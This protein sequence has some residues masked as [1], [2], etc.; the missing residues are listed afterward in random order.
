MRARP[1]CCRHHRTGVTPHVRRFPRPAPARRDERA[2]R[3]AGHRLHPHLGNRLHRRACAGPLRRTA[4]IRLHT[5]RAGRRAVRPHRP[6][7]AAQFRHRRARGGAQ[8]RRRLAAARRLPWLR[9]LCGQRRDAGGHRLADPVDGAD[10]HRRARR[11]AAGR[12]GRAAAMVR[13]RDGP[14]R[15]H[16]DTLSQA[17]RDRL[18]PGADRGVAAGAVL[19]RSA[20]VSTSACALPA[21]I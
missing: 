19:T 11:P 6:R 20:P 21:T 8:P 5:L 16:R 10:I 13:P 4:D 12:K 18:Y 15:R 1:F 14:V 9:L 7:A 3:P 17:R 2:S